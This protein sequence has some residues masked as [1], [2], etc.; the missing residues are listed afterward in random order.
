MRRV[1][2]FFLAAGLCVVMVGVA[3]AVPPRGGTFTDDDGN[4]HEAA[5]EAIA[6]A[7]ITKGC[8]PPANDRYCPSARVTRGQMAAFLVR[9]LNLTDRLHDPFSDDDDSMFE[10]DIERLAAAGITRGCNP[11]DN[12]R[13]CPD[14]A[15]TR[16][17][18]AAFL[19]RA[20]RYSNDG[21]G[22]LFTDD[23]GSVFETDIDRLGAAG[24]TKGC[25]PPDNDRF[26]PDR[27]VLRDQMAS[28]LT[29]ALQLGTTAGPLAVDITT[30]PGERT[31]AVIGP[32][33]GEV[34]GVTPDGLSWTLTVPSGALL[35]ETRIAIA[36]IASVKGLPVGGTFLVGL[37][38]EPDGLRFIRPATLRMEVPTAAVGSALVSFAYRGDGSDTFLVPDTVGPGSVEISVLHFSGELVVSGP[39]NVRGLGV[40]DDLGDVASQQI[41][42]ILLP[43]RDL[44]GSFDPSGTDLEEIASV[45]EDWLSGLLQSFPAVG[46]GARIPTWAEVEGAA[47]DLQR[48]E[49]AI[50]YL[51]IN[52]PGASMSTNAEISAA[53]RLAW[54]HVTKL[55][56]AFDD[57]RESRCA[58]LTDLDAK[59]PMLND[60]LT[61][62]KAV[63]SLGLG[64]DLV[65]VEDTLCD[66]LLSVSDPAASIVVTP[67]H[68]TLA[69]GEGVQLD[70][71]IVARDGSPLTG[72]LVWG[73]SG[74][75]AS[76][77]ATAD[78]LAVVVGDAV[79]ES[80]VAVASAAIPAIIEL[81][82]VTVEA[83]NPDMTVDKT[84]INAPVLRGADANFS[85]VITNTGGTDLTGMALDDPLCD[86]LLGPDESA[87]TNGILDVGEAWTYLCTVFDVQ[88]PFTNSVTVDSNETGRRTASAAVDLT[89]PPVCDEISVTGG[90]TFEVT[91]PPYVT[92]FS[93]EA[94]QEYAPRLLNEGDPE[95]IG[96]STSSHVLPGSGRDRGLDAVMSFSWPLPPG[97]AT[98][99]HPNFV[100]A[101]MTSTD[102]ASVT[103][104]LGSSDAHWVWDERY[105]HNNQQPPPDITY[106]L[107]YASRP[108]GAA[109]TVVQIE[110]L[111]GSQQFIVGN[112]AA[113]ALA[114]RDYNT[115]GLGPPW[116][117]LEHLTDGA[118][119]LY[120]HPFEP[121][122]NRTVCSPLSP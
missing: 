100:S 52:V 56:K 47:N 107:I 8:N 3:V 94:F 66:G 75:A 68:A 20:L 40:P 18:M 50:D 77:E 118:T 21:G 42:M 99:D 104:Q 113:T 36:P 63:D 4:I 29:R 43:T 91:L 7:G 85:I 86:A 23:D 89:I 46:D 22:D 119:I 57:D 109:P 96:L 41:M 59:Q 44:A 116:G 64:S 78:D 102:T 82:P 11:P 93:V 24:V 81:V 84:L 49:N 112:R 31:S 67:S 9:A 10:G 19:V 83:S 55:F 106:S 121:N 61:V 71:D 72:R 69:I 80:T 105:D 14:S 2:L 48:V 114:P 92:F 38:F 12:D 33:G 79:G 70:A 45:L 53:L 26:C 120:G 65:R 110:A 62:Q 5:I 74:S 87:V 15:V 35:E 101:H 108:A 73:V 115:W 17:Q 117:T 1:F 6:A 16:G 58:R 27:P 54:Q 103:I 60:M 30:V 111:V 39:L 88:S 98:S 28:F 90:T 122:S 76:L 25:N 51:D 97:G 37:D 13:F 34:A 95:R 32:G